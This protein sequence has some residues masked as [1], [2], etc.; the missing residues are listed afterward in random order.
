MAALS[1]DWDDGLN[2]DLEIIPDPNHSRLDGASRHEAQTRI[3]GNWRREL[4]FD[5]GNQV[6]DEFGQT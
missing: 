4:G 3:V 5:Q 6:V 2:A 1:V